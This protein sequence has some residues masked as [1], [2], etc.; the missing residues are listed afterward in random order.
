MQANAEGA[1]RPAESGPFSAGQRSSPVSARARHS[2]SSYTLLA[3][4]TWVRLA[5]HR[6]RHDGHPELPQ[7]DD[8]VRRQKLRVRHRGSSKR[9]VGNWRRQDEE[10][11]RHHSQ[12]DK[13]GTEQIIGWSLQQRCVGEIIAHKPTK[14]VHIVADTALTLVAVNDD[15]DDDD[16]R[17][18]SVS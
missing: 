13:Q 2:A 18:I 6:R 14:V 8:Q 12:V 7:R 11:G 17:P 3:H 15:D 5:S 10:Q 16:N 9:C 1:K 4:H